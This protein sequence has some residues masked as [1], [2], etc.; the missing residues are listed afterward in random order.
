MSD[1]FVVAW[2][3]AF[4]RTGVRLKMRGLLGKRIGGVKTFKVDGKPGFVWVRVRIGPTSVETAMSVRNDPGVPHA[5]NLE[6]AVCEETD[7]E[8]Y[9]LGKWKRGDA[10]YP[11]PDDPTGV[12][13]HGHDHG[14]MSG[15]ADDDHAQYHTD[16][17]GDER[18][19]QKTEFTETEQTVMEGTN[20]F[21]ITD[22]GVIKWVSWTTLLT[23]MDT[24]YAV[25][26][27]LAGGQ[28]LSG[29]NAAN[30]DLTL[31]GTAHATRTTSY[32]LL[33][34]N[35]GFTAVGSGT[36]IVTLQ[37]FGNFAVQ[38]TQIF[39][40]VP[41]YV[42]S[43]DIP[44]GVLFSATGNVGF[45]PGSQGGSNTD[46]YA[47]LG[48]TGTSTWRSMIEWANVTSGGHH[49]RLV[50]SGGLVLLGTGLTPS[51]AL[52]GT[53]LQGHNGTDGFAN[54]SKSGIVGAAQTIIADGTSDVTRAVY[55]NGF[56]TNGV[57]QN[58]IVNTLILPGANFDVTT[59]GG[60]N[61]LRFAV[62]AGGALTVIRQAGSS[63]WAFR[64]RIDWT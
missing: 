31:Q 43:G 47:M 57:P 51:N 35:G 38:D 28:S 54:I 19:Y 59:D 32:L 3:K 44:A 39:S 46:I 30:D 36:P 17:R 13:V 33:Q 60:T 20:Q 56:A 5:W 34:P 29:G 62:S 1:R 49:L 21:H 11:Q 27:G 23:V 16:E 6:V 10:S 52:A 4:R 14:G 40:I 45:L 58:I 63:T 7:G 61:T 37:V 24:L 9:I 50:K 2:D 42:G 8:Y 15:L 22:D 41:N 53:L 48:K 12:P 18:Y 55:I 26:A 64:G 25:K